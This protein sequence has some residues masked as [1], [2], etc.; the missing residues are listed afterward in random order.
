MKTLVCLAATLSLGACMESGASK[1]TPDPATALPADAH[2]VQIIAPYTSPEECLAKAEQ[3]FSCRFSLSLCKNGRAGE[4][5]G[6]ILKE[7]AYDVVDTVAHISFTGG[8]SLE[9]DVAAVAEIGSP[10]VHWIVDT[11]N[12]WQ[13]LQ[14]DNIDCSQP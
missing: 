3:P 10:N 4:L 9:F 2:F 7:G 6:D 13:T 5:F 8:E 1:T 12:R 14:F 11:A